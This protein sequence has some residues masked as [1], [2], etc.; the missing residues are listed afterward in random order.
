MPGGRE[1]AH[2]GA[3]LGDQVLGGGDPEPGDAVQ[4]G[5]LPLI[6]LAQGGDLLVQHGDLGSVMA[7]VPE[8]HLQDEGVLGGE[9]RAV[10]CLLP[11][12][13]LAAHHPAGHLREHF[14]VPL[15]DGDRA[16]HGP[17]GDPVD[18]ADHR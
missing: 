8:H 1:G 3:D 6:G 9:E 12:G 14:R 11:P 18:V 5:D 4:L 16:E 7:G 17:A 2:V 15:A 10:Q 13:D